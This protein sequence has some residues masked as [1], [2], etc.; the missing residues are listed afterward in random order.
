[1]A[2]PFAVVPGQ[3]YPIIIIYFTINFIV[4]INA[5]LHD[6]LVGYDLSQHLKNIQFLSHLSW[7]NANQSKEFFSPPL[8]YVFPALIYAI[9]KYLVTSLNI[10]FAIALKS[11]QFMNFLLSLGVTYFLL[12]LCDKARPKDFITKVTAL[13]ILALMPVYY[14]TF[15]QIRPEPYV[16]FFF[17]LAAYLIIQVGT[18]KA[19]LLM[20]LS[21]GVSMGL[22][23]LSR[24]WGFFL[25]F[26]MII[27]FI[28]RILIDK[29]N[30][31][32][33]FKTICISGG[34]ALLVGGWF[35]AYIHSLYGTITAFNRSGAATFSFFNQPRDFYF[36]LPLA[37]LFSI[38][39]RPNFPNQLIPIIYSETW[40]DYWGFFLW[41]RNELRSAPNSLLW[42]LN[43]FGVFPTLL[44]IVGFL[45]GFL[46]FIIS[47]IKKQL[48]VSNS[49]YSLSMIIICVSLLGYGWFIIRY[50]SLGKGDTIKATYI[51]YIF[52]FLCLLAGEVVRKISLRS[53]LL[54]NIIFSGLFIVGVNNLPGLITR[55]WWF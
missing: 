42:R 8:P 22:L 19:S 41:N 1:M 43:V 11:A 10:T 25:F 36:S 49:V 34:G 32:Y 35:Y 54:K 28:W 21:L 12:L 37:Q 38:P 30:I 6:P 29:Q 20:K 40:G 3:R 26:S 16:I 44:L 14:K 5:F 15:S 45:Y 9:L 53:R 39:R 27:F 23:I 24:Q 17:I 46:N 7:P 31:A 48:S 4:L 47:T 52:P 18:Q 13:G 2:Q 33:Y 50:P 55:R 51:I